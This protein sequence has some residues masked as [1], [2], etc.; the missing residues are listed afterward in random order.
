MHR[1]TPS[2][3]VAAADWDRRQTDPS[4]AGSLIVGKAVLGNLG[5]GYRPRQ[6]YLA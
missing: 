4:L 3:G 5:Y 1:D 2:T 6:G